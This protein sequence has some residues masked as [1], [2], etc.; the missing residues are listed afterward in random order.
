MIS[1]NICPLCSAQVSIEQL[2]PNIILQRRVDEAKNNPTQVQSTS[3]PS[4]VHGNQVN[5]GIKRPVP[6]VQPMQPP[7]KKPMVPIRSTP[8]AANRLV[9]RYFTYALIKICFIGHIITLYTMKIQ[10]YYFNEYLFMYIYFYLHF[11]LFVVVFK[12]LNKNMKN[13]R[14]V[15]N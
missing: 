3:V 9:G 7:M 13:K 1:N 11:F 15:Q 2:K 14:S 12:H 10:N 5:R 6:P 8:A 4:T